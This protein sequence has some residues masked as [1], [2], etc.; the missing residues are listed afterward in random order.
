MDTAPEVTV[1][2]A[3]HEA[4][5]AGDVER[6]VGLSSE[7]VE[8]VGP[9]GSG[10]GTPLLREWVARAG[11][12]L[13][14]QRVF[15]RGDTVVAEEQAEWRSSDRGEV[16][17]SQL[18]ASVFRVRDGRIAYIARYPSLAEALEQAGLSEGDERRP[19]LHDGRGEKLS[20]EAR[21]N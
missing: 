6:L 21:T 5:N 8:V 3:W 13:E 12:R 18:L 15:Q 7:V 2:I 10:Y 16:T 9:R 11:I 1:V 19:P 4:L 17:D 14:V 20:G